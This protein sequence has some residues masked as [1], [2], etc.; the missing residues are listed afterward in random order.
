MARVKRAYQSV[1]SYV[2]HQKRVPIVNSYYYYVIQFL[3]RILSK[4]S[5][6]FTVFLALGFIDSDTKPIRKLFPPN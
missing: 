5:D 3:R 4:M 2:F 1:Q 6:N